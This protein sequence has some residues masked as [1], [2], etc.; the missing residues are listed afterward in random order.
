MMSFFEKNK[1]LFLEGLSRHVE[2]VVVSVLVG[3][4]ISVP[5]GILLSRKKSLAKYV[6]AF[7][8]TVRRSGL[9]LLGF[10]MILFGIGKPPASSFYRCM[11]FCDPPEHLYRHTPRCRT[12]ISGGAGHRHDRRADFA[13]VELPLAL[14][15][16]IGGLRLST[17]YIISW[18]TLAGLIGAG[19]LGDLIW[20]GLATYVNRLI[21][22]GAVPSAVM[23]I[24]VSAPSSG[25]SSVS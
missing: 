23:A 15:S 2:L 6:L 10:A 13:Q 20:T 14:P 11:P 9:V 12:A 25:S 19:R 24:V 21:L 1:T 17:V 22:A 16:I 5:L 3:L 4:I 18:A 7:A 8:G